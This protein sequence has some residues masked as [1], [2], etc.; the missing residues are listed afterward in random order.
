MNCNKN[1]GIIAFQKPHGKPFSL[2][3]KSLKVTK[4]ALEYLWS[5]FRVYVGVR[6]LRNIKC[7]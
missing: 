2:L 5:S 6:G 4:I 7:S 1:F 3:R